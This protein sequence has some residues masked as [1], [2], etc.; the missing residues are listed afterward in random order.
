MSKINQFI[1]PIILLLFITG[2]GIYYFNNQKTLKNETTSSKGTNGGPIVLGASSSDGTSIP[3][4]VSDNGPKVISDSN[5]YMY[6]ISEIRVPINKKIEELTPKLQYKTLF[7]KDQIIKDANDTKNMINTGIATLTDMKISPT[8][9]TVNDKEIESLKFLIE[10]MDAL[11]AFEN[12]SDQN[13]QQL[14]SEKLNYMI[15]ESNR[16]I[17]ELQVPTSSSGSGTNNSGNT[18][19][20][21]NT[22]DALQ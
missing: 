21:L 22:S 19:G 13:D 9:K 11:I 16:V 1:I 6:K 10:A 15:S 4:N 7:T 17:K 12:S 8:L 20:S 3:N 14:Q 5:E 18:G 2:G